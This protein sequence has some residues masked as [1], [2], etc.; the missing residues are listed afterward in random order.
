MGMIEVIT[1][2]VLPSLNVPLSA[3]HF[4]NRLLSF[5]EAS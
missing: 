5:Q 3:R 4:F 2:A 1:M